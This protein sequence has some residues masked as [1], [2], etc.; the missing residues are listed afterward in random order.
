MANGRLGGSYGT[1]LKPCWGT[2]GILRTIISPLEPLVYHC[3]GLNYQHGLK[4]KA[5]GILMVHDGTK[6]YETIMMLSNGISPQPVM[7]RPS[8]CKM[9]RKL[10]KVQ[11]VGDYSPVFNNH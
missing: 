10:K 6:Q 11:P 1:S 7:N 9:M 2:N 3:Y 8:R 4:K 5:N